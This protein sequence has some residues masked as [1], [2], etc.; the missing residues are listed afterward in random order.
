MD[1]VDGEI[2]LDPE[3]NVEAVRRENPE[4]VVYLRL[5]YPKSWLMY[6]PGADTPTPIPN[7]GFKPSRII[8]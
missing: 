4:L 2:F 8:T 6:P 1:I 7:G 3:E 5:P